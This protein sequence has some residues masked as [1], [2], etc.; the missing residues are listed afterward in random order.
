MKKKS[1][2]ETS[3]YCSPEVG[4]DEDVHEEAAPNR[5]R[6]EPIPPRKVTSPAGACP[7]KEGRQEEAPDCRSSFTGSVLSIIQNAYSHSR[8]Q[9]TVALST[10]PRYL[11]SRNITQ[12]KNL[13]IYFHI[14]SITF[15][16]I[17]FSILSFKYS[18]A[19][20]V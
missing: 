11:T 16:S 9:H 20:I 15:N 12:H 5:R 1:D 18:S 2:S 6:E 13:Y 10:L 8:N 7:R 14:K 17:Y 4:S 3:L 19:P